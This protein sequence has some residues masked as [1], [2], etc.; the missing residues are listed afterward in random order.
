[1]TFNN[2]ILAGTTLVRD[3]IQSENF[4]TG[5]TGWRIER[6]GD[7]EF[8]DVTVRGE[9]EVVG[10][11]PTDKLT[12][13]LN[14]GT[15][16]IRFFDNGVE[17]LRLSGGPG[18]SFLTGFDTSGDTKNAWQIA[19]NAMTMHVGKTT[20]GETNV[21]TTRT[22]IRA[23]TGTTE[24]ALDLNVGNTGKVNY[25]G[26]PILRRT[27]NVVREAD[28]GTFTAETVID[29]LTATTV[30]GRQYEI[31]WDGFARSS[32]AN[33]RVQIRIREDS[34]AGT[35]RGEAFPR[36][37][38]AAANAT[39]PMRC[40]AQYTADATETKTFVV[41]MQRFS[42]TGNITATGSTAQRVFTRAT[43]FA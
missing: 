42:G 33:D 8:N 5:V 43:E 23:R 41:T 16:Q 22:G 26:I 17:T 2:S 12:A 18:G 1:M 34:I 9:L 15:P 37:D 29:T 30:I 13:S 10:T 7:A 38:N 4:Q 32:V 36:V 31:E 40:V 21:Q 14:S 39:A 6:D 19:T 27:G 3:A 35:S 25:G 20:V 28:V 11:D 24:S